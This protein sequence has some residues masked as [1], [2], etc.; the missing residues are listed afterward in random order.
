[1]D[2]RQSRAL[3]IAATT[4]LAASNGRWKVPS[5]SGNGNYT[6]LVTRR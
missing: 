3:H 2:G 1:M 4:K 6:V 5:Q